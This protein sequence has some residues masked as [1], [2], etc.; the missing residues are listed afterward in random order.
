MISNLFQSKN[1][2]KKLALLLCIS[3][4][5]NSVFL[6]VAYADEVPPPQETTSQEPSPAPTDQQPSP[7][8]ETTTESPATTSEATGDAASQAS[9]D[10]TV[11]Y[12]DTTTTGDVTT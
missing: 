12:T 2:R 6:P 9:S 10:N 11:N 1:F 5:F 4:V 7:A 3:I 8:P